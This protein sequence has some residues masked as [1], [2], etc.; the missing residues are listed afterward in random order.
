M[1]EDSHPELVKSR[2]A[3]EPAP[4]EVRNPQGF[5]HQG[6]WCRV[7]GSG[8]RVRNPRLL[9]LF[10][11]AR[12]PLDPESGN[13]WVQ[14]LDPYPPRGAFRKPSDAG[15]VVAMVVREVL[16]PASERNGNKFKRFKDLP[17][18]LRPE[19]GLDCLMRAIFAR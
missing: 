9:A 5:R 3:M 16:F 12:K 13:S 17:F 6:A 1:S 10:W 14:T 4:L 11:H 7:Q 19:S 2:D 15:Y 8:F 18:K